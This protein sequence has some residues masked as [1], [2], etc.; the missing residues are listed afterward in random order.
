MMKNYSYYVAAVL[1]TDDMDLRKTAR[2]ILADT[3]IEPRKT[4]PQNA[5]GKAQCEAHAAKIS[6]AL[7]PIGL[8][9]HCNEG[10][11][12]KAPL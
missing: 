5:R 8:T 7:A 2:K 4:F 1:F 12:M 11:S 9:A 10:F 6:E 3:K